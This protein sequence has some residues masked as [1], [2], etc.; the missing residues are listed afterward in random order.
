MTAVFLGSDTPLLLSAGTTPMTASHHQASSPPCAMENDVSSFN[1]GAGVVVSAKG[2]EK[3]DAVFLQL[4][5]AAADDVCLLDSFRPSSSFAKG[6]DVGVCSSSFA[7]ENAI[8][9]LGNL[10]VETDLATVGDAP[11]PLPMAAMHDSHDFISSLPIA[12]VL[13][14]NATTPSPPIAMANETS[15]LGKVTGSK[16]V[17]TDFARMGVAKTAF[18]KVG[19]VK[20]DFAK[21]AAAHGGVLA[22]AAAMNGSKDAK[23]VSAAE[24]VLVKR[25]VP[26]KKVIPDQVKPI[27][28][29]SSDEPS[30]PLTHEEASRPIGCEE[31]SQP[32][33]V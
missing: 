29:Q 6:M 27:E 30:W 28:Q 32:N 11:L 1:D 10:A 4:Q 33:D 18:A 12:K 19:V 7:R 2:K 9:L 22:N 13:G 21:T 17:K 15:M 23:V 3:E 14:D 26:V 24:K 8:T 25:W 5:S 16:A 20:T 31:Q